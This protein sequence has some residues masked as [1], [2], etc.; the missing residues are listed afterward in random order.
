MDQVVWSCYCV[1]QEGGVFIFD[2]KIVDFMEVE[3]VFVIFCLIVY[4]I[5]VD[6]V[7]QV[8]DDIEI[9]VFWIVVDIFEVFE[10]DVVDGVFW[11]EMVDQV[12]GCIIDI[13]DGWDDQFGNVCFGQDWF[14]IMIKVFFIGFS[15]VFYVECYV[16]GR[17]IVFFGEEGGLGFWFVIDDEVDIVLVL[18]FDIFGVVVGDV[19]EIYCFE[20]WF[21]D[22]V[23]LSCEFDEFK[24]IK[25]NWVFEQIGYVKFYL[26]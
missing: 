16:I 8:I 1:G 3:E 22:V 9:I 19:G 26:F 5:F 24:I 10:I 4:V 6:V 25:F 13:F 11:I 21:D 14:G 2:V 18:Q 7:C 12:D 17:W 20:D 23:F 15:C